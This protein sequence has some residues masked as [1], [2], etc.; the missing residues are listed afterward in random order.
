M[1]FTLSTSS[2]MV[3]CLLCTCVPPVPTGQVP[4]DSAVLNGPQYV[5]DVSEFR[6]AASQAKFLSERSLQRSR[7]N[8]GM[9]QGKPSKGAG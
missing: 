2:A 6:I 1:G 8:L 5:R 3:S 7:V 4:T 9:K